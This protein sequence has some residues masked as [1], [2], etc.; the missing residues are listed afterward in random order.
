M[1]SMIFRILSYFFPFVTADKG[2]PIR[3][4]LSWD[5]AIFHPISIEQFEVIP[6]EKQK[7]CPTWTET[8]LIN[9]YS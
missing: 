5:T 8:F 9:L 3:D 7:Q 1:M 6:E 2:N 4:M